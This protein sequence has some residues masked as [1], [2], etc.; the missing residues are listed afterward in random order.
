MY[1]YIA[2]L[3]PLNLAATY[4]TQNAKSRW[5]GC[6]ALA[7]Q[8][9]LLTYLLVAASHLLVYPGA[10]V[11]NRWDEM[12]TDLLYT[13][14][15][16]HTGS[17]LGMFPKKDGLCE[18]FILAET[19]PWFWDEENPSQGFLKVSPLQKGKLSI[20][21]KQEK[22]WKASHLWIT[23]RINGVSKINC[24]T[25]RKQRALLKSTPFS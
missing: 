7:S 23:Q 14:R 21:K 16:Y 15:A 4:E 2:C 12:T 19:E 22:T 6:Y 9:P 10:G 11:P 13:L 1:I 3:R 17:F 8:S 24:G 20:T 25:L 5:Q 18:I